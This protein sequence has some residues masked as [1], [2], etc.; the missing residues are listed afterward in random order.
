MHL[1]DGAVEW[2][3]NQYGYKRTEYVLANTVR[4]LHYDGRFHPDNRKW[5]DAHYTPEDE[6]HNACFVVRSH[7]A[8]VDG[9][10]SN[11]RKLA[12]E[13]D[14]CEEQQD[15]RPEPIKTQEMQFGGM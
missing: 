7:P 4:E 1:K 15:L 9:F 6:T 3:V 2:V 5:A 13:H 14:Q 8:I 10:I 11:Y 12:M